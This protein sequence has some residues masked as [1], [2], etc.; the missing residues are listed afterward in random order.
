M[1][2][3]AAVA[4]PEFDNIDNTL[5]ATLEHLQR[6]ESTICRP[7]LWHNARIFPP[8]IGAAVGPTPPATERIIKPRGRIASTMRE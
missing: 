1:A 5:P 7:T 4:T 2:R 6:A 3:F 8:R